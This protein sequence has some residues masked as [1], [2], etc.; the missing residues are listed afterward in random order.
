MKQKRTHNYP[1]N[2][3]PRDTSYSES[4]RL[5]NEYGLETIKE[6]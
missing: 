5:V 4:Y 6:I 1:E 2:R 3:K